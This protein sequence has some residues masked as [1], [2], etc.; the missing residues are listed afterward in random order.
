MKFLIIGCGSIGQRHI[1]NLLNMGY[2]NIEVF[3]ANHMLLTKVKRELGIK[4]LESLKFNDINCTLV[5]TPP[6]THVKLAKDAL[7]NNSHVFIEKPLS[8]TINGLGEL[9]SISK[10]KSLHIFV[11]YVFRFDAGLIRVKQMLSR[12]V[13]G[14]VLSLD[15]YEGWYLPK[16]RPWQ[17]HTKSYTGSRK[18]GG[19]IILDGS[20]EVN[21]LQWLGGKIT[22]VFSYYRPVPKLKVKTEGLAEILLTF[23]SK[24]IGRIHLDFINPRYNRHCEIIG[25][26]GSIKW[27]FEKKI[28][29]IQKST[30]STSQKIKY[31]K[32]TNKMYLDEMKH[33]VD[34][35]NG[36]KNNSEITLNQAKET[37]KISLAI[38][39][40]GLINK[41]VLI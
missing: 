4:T 7:R 27:S 33:V 21:Y 35:I 36:N 34:C 30:Q 12:K 6:S 10:K 19:G 39:K 14:N 24:A 2:N 18:L 13:I 5:C 37:L 1:R 15:S 9:D 22:Q 11:G 40:S 25:D 8:N 38:K 23:R 31:G 17:D 28:I 41:P 26:E 29:E 16:W 20:H 3:D 32:D